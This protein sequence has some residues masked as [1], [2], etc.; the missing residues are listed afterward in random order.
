[1]NHPLMIRK[2]ATWFL[3][4][5]LVLLILAPFAV[6]CAAQAIK[7]QLYPI[8]WAEV[9]VGGEIGR[10]IAVTATNNVLSLNVDG[11]FLASFEKK[12]DAHNSYVAL[13]KLIDSVA[14][15]A[16]YTRDEKLIALKE[17]LT[18]EIIKWQQPDGYIGNMIPES[19]MWKLWDI[20]EMHYIIFGLLTDYKLFGEQRSLVAAKRAADYILNNWSGMPSDWEQKLDLAA[21]VSMTGLDRTMLRLYSVT[22]DQRY[23]EFELKQRDLVNWNPGIVIGR[24]PLVEGHAYSYM[25]TALA[26]ARI[27]PHPSGGEVTESGHGGGTFHD[28]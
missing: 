3:R 26:Q 1:M 23:L 27:V 28:R 18:G 22:G 12:D 13:G 16:Y 9:R 2:K 5:C 17:H 10:R 11:D 8:D 21:S 25:S 6:E 24:R 19:R 15:L 4:L 14:K 20:H 7:D